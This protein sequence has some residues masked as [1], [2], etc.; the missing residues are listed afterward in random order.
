LQVFEVVDEH[1]V[2]CV[3]KNEAPHDLFLTVSLT[4][5][6]QPL[7]DSLHV[8]V[9]HASL[10]QAVEVVNELGAPRDLFLLAPLIFVDH[11]Y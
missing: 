10:P 7:T 2:V 9:A 8:P 1:D 6:G 4:R 5:G 3:T 11:S